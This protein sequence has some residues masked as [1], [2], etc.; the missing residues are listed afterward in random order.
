MKFSSQDGQDK[1]VANLF[2]N[3]RKGVFID[4]GAYDGIYYSN[5]A[6]FEK[7]LE[8]EGICVEPNPQVFEKLKD[9]RKCKCINCCIYEKQEIL[10][11]VSVSGYGEMLSG[12]VDFFDEKHLDRIDKTIKEHGGR[13]IIIDISGFPVKDILEKE[14]ITSIDYCNIDVEG[15]EMSVLNSIDFSKVKI[16]VFT[17]E[18]NYRTKMIRNFLYPLGYKLIGKLGADEVYEYQSRR[19]A[20][21]IEWRI[22]N[23]TN[24]FSLLSKSVKRKF[25]PNTK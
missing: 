18:N 24:Y 14:S 2:K 11:F 20:L 12:L 23:I 25:F 6:Y 13:K 7:Y 22:N 15:G 21:M 16:K 3:K 17:I 4:I 8:W 19:Y 5:T 1:F 10:K 9:N